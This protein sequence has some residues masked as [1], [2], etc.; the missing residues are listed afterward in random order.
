L[1]Y[2]D[3]IQNKFNRFFGEKLTQ[4]QIWVNDSDTRGIE[5]RN[6][7][8]LHFTSGFFKK[9]QLAKIKGKYSKNFNKFWNL[10]TEHFL[11]KGRLE[12]G[13]IQKTVEREF[14]TAKVVDLWYKGYFGK[15]KVLRCFAVETSFTWLRSFIGAYLGRKSQEIGIDP[16]GL[17]I[18]EDNNGDDL[19][20]VSMRGF[21]C[22][23]FYMKGVDLAEVAVYYGGG[24][25]KKAS[26]FRVH[27]KDKG[28]L[29]KNKLIN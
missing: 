16:A 13:K 28:N 8:S 2:S 21:E 22:Y 19:V 7:E 9:F 29:F 23:E 27:K 24:G 3:V 26:C 10:E 4:I 1:N 25:H 18:M 15:V 17:V 14:K 6:K 20:S 11:E 12:Y 5:L